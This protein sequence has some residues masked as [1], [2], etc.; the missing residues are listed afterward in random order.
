MSLK[1]Y[2]KRLKKE[3]E[4]PQIIATF[5]LILGAI[6]D[7]EIDEGP[8]DLEKI[9]KTIGIERRDGLE[10]VREKLRFAL[11][12]SEKDLA[13]FCG[14]DQDRDVTF[15]L[16]E[17]AIRRDDES[18]IRTLHGKDLSTESQ[19]R[20]ENQLER[21]KLVRESLEGLLKWLGE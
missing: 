20:K 1:S 14:T 13:D 10:Q 12:K 8:L 21:A 19:W 16:R 7:G 18:K 2:K 11:N 5:G 3:G 17:A 9:L 4:N 6:Y 15:L